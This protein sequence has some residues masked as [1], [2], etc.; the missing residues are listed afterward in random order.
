MAAAPSWEVTLL[1]RPAGGKR[2]RVAGRVVVHAPD[3]ARARRAAQEALLARSGG[4]PRWSL[5]VLRPLTP[6]APG[7]HRYRVTFAVW[8]ADGDGY[9]R[10]DVHAL[11]VWAADAASARRLAQQEIQREPRYRPAWRIRQVARAGR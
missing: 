4:E 5:G 11:E 1:R 3:V 6:Q 2:A 10:R 7:T 9:E 8:E